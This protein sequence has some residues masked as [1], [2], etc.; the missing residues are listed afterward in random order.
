M[1]TKPGLKREIIRLKLR[2]NQK[3]KQD[4]IR[5]KLGLNKEQKRARPA[6]NDNKTRTG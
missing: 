4:Y 5:T 3:Q 1:R 2:Q 6:L